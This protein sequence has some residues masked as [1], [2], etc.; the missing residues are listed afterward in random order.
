MP[1]LT[2]WGFPI[3][4]IIGIYS[5][6]IMFKNWSVQKEFRPL[7]QGCS[8]KSH[9][10]PIIKFPP[11]KRSETKLGLCLIAFPYVNILCAQLAHKRSPGK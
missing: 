2:N 4:I 1:K 3:Q 8:I 6:F 9:W 10:G 7:D 5:T 11:R